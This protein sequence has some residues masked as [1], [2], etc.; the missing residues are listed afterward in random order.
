MRVVEPRSSIG[1]DKRALASRTVRSER[2]LR[3]RAEYLGIGL[4]GAP[5]ASIAPDGDVLRRGVPVSPAS[6][7]PLQGVRVLLVD[8]DE[9]TREL[10]ALVLRGAGAEVR[11]ALDAKDAMRT[12]LQWPPTI[13]VSDLI[14][15]TMD[16]L[17]LLREIRSVHPR[18][19]AIAVT[20]RSDAKD[21]EAALAAGF[22]DLV[23][24][25]VDPE[26]LVAIVGQSR[27]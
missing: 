23:T 6:A 27:R 10:F 21:R 8:D 13:M 11:T 15:P 16:G 17:T 7:N 22:Q 12:I 25:P 9:D 3:G 4:E 20:G 14:L 18:V 5:H 1:G 19:R 26:T 2:A 24:K